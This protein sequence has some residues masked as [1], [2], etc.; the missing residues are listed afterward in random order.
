MSRSPV[1][2]NELPRPTRAV[3]VTVGIIDAGLRAWILADLRTRPADQVNGPKVLWGLAL[4][5]VQLG[6][7]PAGGLRPPG[8][9]HRSKLRA[10]EGARLTSAPASPR[11]PR[12]GS[13]RRRP[14]RRRRARR[15]ARRARR[16]SAPGAG[17][18]RGGPGRDDDL[19]AAPVAGVRATFGVPARHEPVDDS[20]GCRRRHPEC[21]GELDRPHRRIHEVAQRVQLRGREP[22]A[23][24][25]LVWHLA[26]DVDEFLEGVQARGRAVLGTTSRRSGG[27]F[28]AFASDPEVSVISLTYLATW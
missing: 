22:G 13:A 26:G 9:P 24:G 1:V 4:D 8:P 10:R 21:P 28:H 15:R 11:W 3:V 19:G 16:T 6:G 7:H 18:P 2:W 14:A 5:L 23:A 12:A 20:R 25:D 17:T 27:T